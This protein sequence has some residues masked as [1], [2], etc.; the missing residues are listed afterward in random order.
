MYIRG[1]R[2]CRNRPRMSRDMN[3]L[4]CICAAFL[5]SVFA[6]SSVCSTQMFSEVGGA[7]TYGERFGVVSGCQL[8]VLSASFVIPTSIPVAEFKTLHQA[9][10]EVAMITYFSQSLPNPPTIHNL[11][12]RVQMSSLATSPKALIVDFMLH[13]PHRIHG[14][15]DPVQVN[16][17]L[18]QFSIPSGTFIAVDDAVVLQEI[19]VVFGTAAIIS[20]SVGGVC[21]IAIIVGICYCCRDCGKNKSHS[22]KK[23][24]GK[25]SKSH[26]DGDEED[27]DEEEGGLVG[28]SDDR[29][30]RNKKKVYA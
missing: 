4:L 13:S 23:T 6:Q 11:T 28:G 15:I 9:D 30:G 21:L 29:N 24:R 17:Y 10:F 20:A 27:E 3:V 26:P 5:H 2:V 1:E 7:I 18:A 25:K 12:V 14:T 16:L 19:E 8:H 22:D